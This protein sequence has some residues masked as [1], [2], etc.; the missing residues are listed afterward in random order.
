MR[1]CRVLLVR[2]DNLDL[3][4]GLQAEIVHQVVAIARAG[5]N[6]KFGNDVVTA[7]Y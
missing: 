5:L 2:K 4:I 1:S 7:R 3:V 6:Y